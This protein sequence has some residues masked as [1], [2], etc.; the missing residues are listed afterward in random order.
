M[1]TVDANGKVFK[2]SRSA[3]VNNLTFPPR[4]SA[5][6]LEA[7]RVA[8]LG[9][10]GRVYT[11]GTHAVDLK[12]GD[13]FSG[14]PDN[15]PKSWGEVMQDMDTGFPA[16]LHG[17]LFNESDPFRQEAASLRAATGSTAG[18]LPAAAQEGFAPDG[19]QTALAAAA[20]AAGMAPGGGM[21]AVLPPDDILPDL[22]LLLE[23]LDAPSPAPG[24]LGAPG[25]SKG[26]PDADAGLLKALT[27][28][29]SFGQASEYLQLH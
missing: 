16:F 26:S 14:Y 6:D 27:D 18:G 11:L 2:R 17:L 7:E 4:G 1:H 25:Q 24:P 29:G 23:Q 3:P 22:N 5:A 13:Y 9:A 19:A 8:N 21:G 15:T 10:A 12:V 28:L 20:A